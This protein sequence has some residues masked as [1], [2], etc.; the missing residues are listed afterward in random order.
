M[1]A[2]DP[3]ERPV[4]AAKDAPEGAGGR[5]RRVPRPGDPFAKGQ[6]PIPAPRPRRRRKKGRFFFLGLLVVGGLMVLV[7]TAVFFHPRQLTVDFYRNVVVPRGIPE[8]LPPDYPREDAVRLLKTL[9]AFFARADKGQESDERVVEVIS[10]IEAAMADRRI[11][12]EEAEGLIAKA[13]PR[14]E[15]G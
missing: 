3:P 12:P 5:P 9:D 8:S 1:S 4:A 11:T 13:S 15:G 7:T 2:P 10:G 6:S 14:G